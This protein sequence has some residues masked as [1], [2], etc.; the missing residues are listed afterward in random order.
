MGSIHEVIQSHHSEILGMW[1]EAA[2]QR[3]SARGLTAHEL[4]G[5]MPAFLAA[6]GDQE[7]AEPA[8]LS[9]GQRDLIAHHLS[10][11][12]RHGF[13][14]NEILTEFA[15]L[16]RCVFRCL[17]RD[18]VGDS[19]EVGEV[20]AALVLTA[21]EVTKIFNEQMLEDEQALKRSVRL[22]RAIASDNAGLHDEGEALHEGLRQMLEVVRE[23]MSADAVAWLLLDARTR[24]V[25][26][27][28]ATGGAEEALEE[29]LRSTDVAIFAARET[30]SSGDPEAFAVGDVDTVELEPSDRLRRGG[31]GSLLAMRLAARHSL[32]GILYVA[33]P[34]QHR[35]SASEVRRLESLGD[36]L[37]EH[38]EQAHVHAA[39]R[40]KLE[41]ARRATERS[42]RFESSFLHALDRL[43][44]EACAD[45]RRLLVGGVA[46]PMA[47]G[48]ALLRNLETTRGTVTDLLDARRIRR[49][50]R[51]AL[52]LGDC[53]LVD[54]ARA[55]VDEQQ[56]RYGDRFIVHADR[57][58]R[59]IWDG[60]QLAPAL[61]QLL[62]NA[63]EHGDRAAPIFV[64][65]SGRTTGA[66]LS[67]HNA[68]SSITPERQAHLF[69]P[70]AQPHSPGLGRH[71]HG[72]GV[73]LTLVWGCAEAHGGRVQVQSAPGKGTTF[74]LAL[75]SDAR[76]YADA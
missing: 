56:Q 63:V 2:R 22:L 23:A 35:F 58:V 27:S 55:V 10:G 16:G 61:K 30:R 51:L 20:F 62:A 44:A 4:T 53:D 32:R 7:A 76:A 42:E 11:R 75:P 38:F 70:F 68:G 72:W 59:G 69:A 71:H 39:L 40:G 37:R 9:D 34:Q 12:L 1:T 15:A 50:A 46:D 52:A 25:I 57:A 67:V 8:Q 47:F 33:A 54:L 5:T 17:R 49:G 14:L 36:V 65:V 19:F 21:V 43:L 24:R 18:S 45:A 74:V 66:E 3:A 64:L 26:V 29:Y 6:L 13:E 60:R 41:A 73:G 28:A 31:V 48:L